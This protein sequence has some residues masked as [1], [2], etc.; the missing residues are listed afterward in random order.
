MNLE[1]FLQ[2]KSFKKYEKTIDSI[3]EKFIEM[4][5]EKYLWPNYKEQQESMKSTQ[6]LLEAD[7]HFVANDTVSKFMKQFEW[8]DWENEVAFIYPEDYSHTFFI[9]REV[10]KK[11]EKNIIIDNLFDLDETINHLTVFNRKNIDDIA[12][13]F[14]LVYY[15][16]MSD[17]FGGYKLFGK[18]LMYYANALCY[19]GVDLRNH[20]LLSLLAHFQGNMIRRDTNPFLI[21]ECREATQLV[22]EHKYFKNELELFRNLYELILLEFHNWYKNTKKTV[23]GY[24][25]DWKSRK[26]NIFSKLVNDGVIQSKWKS[27]ETLFKIIKSKYPSAL[28]QHRPS[29]LSPQSLDIFIPELK[30][31]IEYQGIQHYESIDYFGGEEGFKHRVW[32]DNEKRRKCSENSIALIEWNYQESINLAN[33]NKKL[34]AV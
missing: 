31:G 24:T 3:R 6:L 26:E 11:A 27:E 33:L 5:C 1:D 20:V 4:G 29:W 25:Y 18:G 19:N 12:F 22:I 23:E 2:H 8:I 16:F 21:L 10:V 9:I 17:N 15:F 34:S 30:I 32:L 13:M 7:G 28:Y 14:H